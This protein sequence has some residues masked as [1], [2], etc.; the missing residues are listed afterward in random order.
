MNL[1]Q[2]RF[3]S[4][5]AS[6]GSFTAA[7]AACA[8]TQPTLSNAIAQLEEELGQKLFL[9]TTRRVSLTAF[10]SHVLPDI[11]RVLGAQRA[12]V[13]RAQAFL[14]PQ[15]PLIRIGT[16]PLLDGRFLNV[17]FEPFRAKWPEIELVLREMNM[18]DLNRMLDA[19]QLDFVFGVEE[20]KRDQRASAYLYR[21]PLFYLP[22]DGRRI[23][24]TQGNSVSFDDIAS[25][26]FVMVPDGCGLSRTVRGLFRSH[27][28]ELHEY[29]GEAMS[30]Q[31]LEQWAGLGIGAAI[32]P[33]SKLSA[34]ART[35][36]RLKDRSGEEVL[37]GF[38]AVWSR[39]AIKLP[40]L[41]EFA[42]YLREV[43]PVVATGLAE[44]ATSRVRR[45]NAAA[46]N[47]S[48]C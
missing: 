36:L 48:N 14:K 32:L 2:L 22:P 11:E 7:A 12:L 44:P 28:R 19:E 21:E 47:R 38:E 41:A 13:Q 27:R 6:N 16:S 20:P 37:L 26:M 34:N 5:L 33:R 23:V 29:S 15:K 31:V 3:A 39:N 4:A 35:A 1:S 43:V 30:Y 45:K 9:R 25:D 40:H 42:N 46:R 8:V 10:G 18:A 17:L 24:S